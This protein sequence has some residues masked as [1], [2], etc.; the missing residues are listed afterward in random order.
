MYIHVNT[1]P[2][3][4]GA[5]PDPSGSQTESTG[6]RPDPTRI[7]TRP[8]GPRCPPGAPPVATRWT[9]GPPRAI[10]FDTL[11]D[12]GFHFGSLGLHF[13]TPF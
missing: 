4:N 10:F 5:Q 13:R 7:Q 12:F 8:G 6:S 2:D 3:P 11:G 1:E 9:P